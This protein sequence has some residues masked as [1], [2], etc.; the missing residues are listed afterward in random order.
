MGT[1]KNQ[2]KSLF[3]TNE[4]S[5]FNPWKDEGDEDYLFCGDDSSNDQSCTPQSAV[6]NRGKKG[7]WSNVWVKLQMK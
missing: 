2:P 1:P 5:N 7:V 3:L 6:E 4:K